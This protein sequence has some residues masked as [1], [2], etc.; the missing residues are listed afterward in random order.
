MTILLFIAPLLA[1]ACYLLSWTR[2]LRGAPGV[3]HA[4]AAGTPVA[5][6]RFDQASLL[7]L[8]GLACHL[9]SLLAGVSAERGFRFGFGL[10]LSGT[11]W[12]GV[13]VL[14]FEGLSVRA[15]ALRVA[16]LP[17]AAI[18]GLLPALFP[19]ADFTTERGL[20]LFLPHLLVGTLAYG[21][22]M[23]AAL[24]AVLMMMAERALHSA[25]TSDST[26]G[27]W[28]ERLPPLLALERI[29]FRFIT[30]GF[31]LLTLTTASGV[32]FSEQ[33]FGRPLRFD[34]K[35]VFTLLSWIMFGALLMGRQL[36]GWRGRTALRLTL[37]GFAVLLLG[38]IGSRFVI[39]VILQ[40]G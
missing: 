3:S 38:Y 17:V 20:P 28:I 25:V 23:L 6:R 14:W 29:L 27:R 19:G 18:A 26:F 31:V 13:A 30:L 21:V 15:E 11:F 35:T 40:R 1:A 24:H 37:G 16:V 12:V 5:A 33:V 4:D 22:L 34:H 9:V 10:A 7:L 2:S 8:A 39:E 36:W 32:L